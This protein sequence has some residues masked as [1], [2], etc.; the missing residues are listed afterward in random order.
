MSGVVSL[1][2]PSAASLLTGS[3]VVDP[4]GAGAAGAAIFGGGVAVLAGFVG[5]FL[6]AILLVLGLACGRSVRR[7]TSG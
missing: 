6:G 5:F 4:A 1:A 7:S 2:L 3:H